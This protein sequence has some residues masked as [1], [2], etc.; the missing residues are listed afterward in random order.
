T[1]TDAVN[2]SQLFSV[3]K[4]TLDQVPMVYTKADGTKLFKKADGS[5]IDTQ[6]RPVLNNQVIVSL[7][8][9]AGSTTTPVV[10]NNLTSGLGR[11]AG[12]VTNF[13]AKRV[14]DSVAATVGDI[15]H[16]AWYL[17]TANAAGGPNIY[18]E[19][20]H[21]TNEVRFVGENGVQISAQ[22]DRDKLL[23]VVTV[24]GTSITKQDVEGGYDLTIV[25][26]DGRRE[27]MN[28]RNGAKG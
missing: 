18:K 2:G 17:T 13:S 8:D 3:A 23:H 14:E 20:V 10:L 19:A 25:H 12:G 4:G 22:G 16:M 11:D 6:S 15:R 1:S 21:S 7:Q 26:P 24:K 27:V 28:I 5:F 9:A